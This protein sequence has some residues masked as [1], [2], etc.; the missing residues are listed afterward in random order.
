MAGP[1][2]KLINRRF[3]CSRRRHGCGAWR[4]ASSCDRQ[5]DRRI[6]AYNTDPRDRLI[7]TAFQLRRL[8][9]RHL[10]P[11]RLD[12]GLGNNSSPKVGGLGTRPTQPFIPIVLLLVNLVNKYGYLAAAAAVAV[13][14]V[15]V[16][17]L[18]WHFLG[19]RKVLTNING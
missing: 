7:F 17:T 19:E 5:T 4:G 1:A 9:D 13:V 10:N 15:I 11:K 14:V 6:H 8:G 2:R 3:P 12:D 18:V 16:V